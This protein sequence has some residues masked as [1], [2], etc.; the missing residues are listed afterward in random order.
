IQTTDLAGDGSAIEARATIR[1]EFR[2]LVRENARFWNASGVSVEARL[3]SFQ[4][5]VGPVESWLRGRVEFAVPEE[6]GAEAKNGTRFLLADKPEAEWL[7]WSPVLTSKSKLG[8]QRPPMERAVL[9]WTTTSWFRTKTETASGWLV[10]T[11]AGYLGPRE[12]FPKDQPTATLT[13]AGH[14][15]ALAAAEKSDVGKDVVLLKPSEMPAVG[16]TVRKAE[17]PEDGYLVAGDDSPVFIAAARLTSKEGRWVIDPA[18][19]LPKTWAGAAFVAASDRA[20]IGVFG[21]K[22]EERWIA[23]GL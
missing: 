13:F 23:P 6:P 2:P 19:G 22:E 12:L 11:K 16:A 1:P 4:V 20:V 15:I 5:R 7:T 10:P 21:S 9:T 3:T 17:Q 14:S 8:F 18:I